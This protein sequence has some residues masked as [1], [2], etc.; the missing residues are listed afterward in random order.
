MLY[1]P[2]ADSLPQIVICQSDKIRLVAMATLSLAE[3]KH[4]SRRDLAHVLLRELDRA[5]CV[6]DDQIGPDI[7]RMN[8][9]VEFVLD[10]KDTHTLALVAPHEADVDKGMVSVLTPV[11]AALIGLKPGQMMMMRSYEGNLHKVR[12]TAVSDP[13]IS[14]ATA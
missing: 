12:V 6:A 13:N 11:G 9:R 8:S 7:V 14:D 10:N 2:I 4:S 3:E 5:D 1:H